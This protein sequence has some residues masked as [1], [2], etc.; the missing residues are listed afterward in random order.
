MKNKFRKYLALLLT[1]LM[2]ASCM[3]VDALAAI[4]PVSG[5]TQTSSGISLR[6]I[7][8]PPVATATYIFMN[9]DTEFDRQSLKHNETRKNPGTP[10]AEREK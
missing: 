4:V 5:G 7:V 6:S 1:V 8:R 2:L 3:P 10:A 9:G